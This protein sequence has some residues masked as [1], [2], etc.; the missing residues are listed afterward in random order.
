MATFRFDDDFVR[1]RETLGEASQLSGCAIHAYVL[2]TNHV[3]LLITPED[4]D[5]V[6]RVMQAIGR[7]YVRYVNARHQR[8]GT[9]WEGRFRSSVI[10]SERYLFTCS[11]YIELNPVRAQMVAE[12]VQ[13][14][15]SSYCHN[16]YG[17]PDPLITPPSQYDSLGPTAADRRRTYRALFDAPLEESTLRRIRRATERGDALGDERFVAHVE[18]AL[19][20]P[21]TRGPRGGD[22][23]SPAARSKGSKG[24]EQLF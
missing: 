22:R 17:D 10:D 1:Y 18:A 11:R 21:V 15:W 24:S 6:A 7:H 14:Q 4:H 19:Q 16:A 2:M 5:S 12:P 20:R 9:L 3:H 23:R 13:Y 8:K